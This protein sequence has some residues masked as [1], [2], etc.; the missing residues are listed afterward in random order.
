M[1]LDFIIDN[2]P[3]IPGN[4]P[5]GSLL[6]GNCSS[7]GLQKVKAS[8]P[9]SGETAV[10]SNRKSPRSIN[11]Q[12]YDANT[13]TPL[14]PH[15]LSSQRSGAVYQ[16]LASQS[17]CFPVNSQ[18][19]K[20]NGIVTPVKVAANA[21]CSF[22]N[23]AAASTKADSTPYWTPARHTATGQAEA[24]TSPALLQ[25]GGLTAFAFAKERP[26]PFPRHSLCLCQG[27]AFAFAKARPLPLPRN[28]LSL[29]QGKAFAFAK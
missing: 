6:S 26:F 4:S 15:E 11:G 14:S 21:D 3:T 17:N 12:A 29:G 2:L 7:A 28:V 22:A 9:S 10:C 5:L 23:A 16:P 19:A 27:T 18:A 24:S 25:A 13:G 1:P 8:P 20:G